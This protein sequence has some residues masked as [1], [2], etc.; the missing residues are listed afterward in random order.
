[1][2]RV[3][4]A[5][6]LIPLVLALVFK[7]PLWAVASVVGLFLVLGVREYLD[8]ISNYGVRPSRTATWIVVG[9]SV[10]LLLMA[11]VR[12]FSTDVAWLMGLLVL[13]PYVLFVGGFRGSGPR[14]S[15][16][17]GA[18][19]AL[20]VPWV[21][22]PMLLL[23]AFRAAPNGWFLLFFLLLVVWSGDIFAYYVGRAIGT[24]KL[25]PNIS[26]NK[27][28]EGAVASVIGSATLA[29]ALA[30]WRLPLAASLS[31]SGLVAGVTDVHNFALP[32]VVPAIVAAAVINVAAQFGD[33][34]ESLLK[35]GAGVKDSGSLL[36]G[37][38]GILDRI[39][40]LLFASPVAAVAFATWIW[41]MQP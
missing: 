23:V 13:A 39:D 1:M 30:N 4:T 24:H 20:I 21:M 9:L 22:V 32:G 38:G 14:E 35:R 6:V 17:G 41:S 3:L 25:A 16:L 31:D 12:G 37:H 15:V 36:P 8:L 11:T 28:W 29:G 34:A 26:P 7:G 18:L 33:L 5:L 2:K 40:A 10:G 27:S 19:S